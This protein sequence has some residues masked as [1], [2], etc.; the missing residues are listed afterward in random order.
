MRRRG[1]MLPCTTAD[2]PPSGPTWQDLANEQNG[3]NGAAGVN[4]RT[5]TYT[6]IQ[7]AELAKVDADEDGEKPPPG[8]Q[9]ESSRPLS[10]A[11]LHARRPWLFTANSYS[12]NSSKAPLRAWSMPG[13]L[14]EDE[15]REWRAELQSGMNTPAIRISEENPPL[16]NDSFSPPSSLRGLATPSVLTI[17]T[18]VD[19]A[20]T[21]N[22]PSPIDDAPPRSPVASYASRRSLDYERPPVSL[23]RSDRG[24]R[25]IADEADQY[26]ISHGVRRP[27]LHR[28]R[29]ES[30]AALL[31]R[32]DSPSGSR[33]STPR[34]VSE[35][36]SPRWSRTGK[37]RA[38]EKEVVGYD[39]NLLG[40][41]DHSRRDSAFKRDYQ[42]S[43]GESGAALMGRPDAEELGIDRG[44]GSS[45]S[46]KAQE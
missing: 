40:S 43:R 29:G 19:P 31:G 26:A 14:S 23:G 24:G 28:L 37:E 42:R 25:E 38:R 22:L 2:L 7:M 15:L 1:V 11:A 35:E 3:V 33:S 13:H 41:G 30:R 20:S 17:S 27:D 44:V 9:N 34:G 21:S 36:G 6:G 12:S 39:S 32:P 4:R 46:S 8:S 5:S 18:D 16:F 10:A 45:S